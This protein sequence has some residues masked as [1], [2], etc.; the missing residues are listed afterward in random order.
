MAVSEKSVV[1]LELTSDAKASIDQIMSELPKTRGEQLLAAFKIAQCIITI[2]DR[3]KPLILVA[4]NIEITNEPY[5]YERELKFREAISKLSSNDK[6]A[7]EQLYDSAQ[8]KPGIFGFAVD[9]KP[10]L[11]LAGSLFKKIF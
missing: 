3:K 8:L 1:R 7:L 11:K 9:L 10:L 4:G 5:R 2:E 6:T